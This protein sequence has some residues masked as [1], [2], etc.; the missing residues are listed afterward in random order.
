[1]KVMYYIAILPPSTVREEIRVF[2]EE[3]RSRFQS[4]HALRSPAHITLQM[5]F[6][7]EEM[8]E[9]A[10]IRALTALSATLTP[11]YCELK[12]FDHFGDRVIFVDVVPNPALTAYRKQLQEMLRTSF[13]FSDSKLP[14]RFHPH[15]T[16]ANRDL[17]AEKFEPCM[18]VFKDRS[19]YRSFRME[20]LALLKHRGDYWEVY[21]EFPF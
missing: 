7:F 1:M 17:T 3:V 16:I 2:K 8:K 19:Y 13:G 5:P 12:N 10:L 6:H 11:A 20:G 4:Q 9:T 21:R 15:I 14:E 18:L